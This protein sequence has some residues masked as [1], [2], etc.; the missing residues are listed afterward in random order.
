M[1]DLDALLAR[2]GL[3]GPPTLTELH[4]AY[5]T[6]I[7]FD[8]LTIQLGEQGPLDLDAVASRLCGGGGRGGY[9][10]EVNGVLG[11]MLEQLGHDVRR[12]RAIVGPRGV[13]APVNHLA[14]IVDG[15]W[16][17][18]AGYGEGPVEPL[19]LR[20]GRQ[21]SWLLEPEDGDGW[22]VGDD[23]AWTSGE[24]FTILPDVVGMDAFDE[25]HTRLSTSP[26]SPFVQ[27]LVIQQ[28]RDDFVATL[29]ARTFTV[30]GPERDERRVLD[31]A[32]GLDATLRAGFGIELDG[33]RVARL[34]DAACAQ[35]ELFL[36]R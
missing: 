7:P 28:P 9:C 19:A 17:A 25:P 32:A 13:D 18:E 15:T 10:F 30:R 31:D 33:D 24:G 6:A 8:D 5:V 16:I 26:D 4:R 14:L 20:A 2:I 1:P 23:R 12:H 3:D 27:T 36:S 29:R 11:W 34:W 22:W 35:H 21:D